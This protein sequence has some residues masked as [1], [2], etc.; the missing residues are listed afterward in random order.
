[1][2]TEQHLSIIKGP[3]TTTWPTAQAKATSTIKQFQ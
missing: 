1:L 3:T 2:C